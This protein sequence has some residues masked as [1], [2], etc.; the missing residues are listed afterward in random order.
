KSEQRYD[1]T[2]FSINIPN[3]INNWYIRFRVKIP[4]THAIKNLFNLHTW[5]T[6]RSSFSEKH[7]PGG[8]FYQSVRSSVESVDFRVNDKRSLNL[9]LLDENQCNFLKLRKLHF[10]LIYDIDE[11]FIFSTTEPKKARLLENKVWSEY[12]HGVSGA[13]RKYCASHW[14]CSALPEEGW[15]IFLKIRFASA[16]ILTIGLYIVLITSIAFIVNIFSAF[17][18]EG[19]K[20]KHFP[21]KIFKIE[22]EKSA[23]VKENRSK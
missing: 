15:E 16:N 1:G 2:L 3:E 22:A 11:D 23:P 12:L 5:R 13:N 14:S 8:S 4:Y 21:N 7:T 19:L 17:C 10:F 6:I 20:Q 9:S 18:Y